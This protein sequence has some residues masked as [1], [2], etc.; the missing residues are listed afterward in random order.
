MRSIVKSKFKI[1]III[2]P[3]LKLEMNSIIFIKIDS[4][5]KSKRLWNLMMS[6]ERRKSAS[7]TIGP[8]TWK[9]LQKSIFDIN[10]KNID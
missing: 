8:I 6:L 7:Q 4:S 5:I 10:F 3:S 9:K 2:N 1:P